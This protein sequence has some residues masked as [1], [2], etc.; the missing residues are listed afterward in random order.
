M[1]TFYIHNST[2][3]RFNLQLKYPS[4][5]DKDTR[6]QAGLWAVDEIENNSAGA[7]NLAYK[8]RQFDYFNDIV[9]L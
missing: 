8:G 2:V 6:L 9:L 3:F 4:I 1:Q 5:D 7:N